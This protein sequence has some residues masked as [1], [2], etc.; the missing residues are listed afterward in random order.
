ME[1]EF[2]LHPFPSLIERGADNIPAHNCNL[3]DSR[4]PG[5]TSFLTFSIEQFYDFSGR[6]EI[7]PWRE[8]DEIKSFLCRKK[9]SEQIVKHKNYLIGTQARVRG[10]FDV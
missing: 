9:V 2:H 5:K 7:L 3:Y 1:V 6:G 10:G 4:S 8:V